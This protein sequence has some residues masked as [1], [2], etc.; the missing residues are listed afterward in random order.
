MNSLWSWHA[1]PGRLTDIWVAI[2]KEIGNNQLSP[3]HALPHAAIIMCYCMCHC[4]CC[5]LHACAA[6][7]AA[8]ATA[9]IGRY[10]P[11]HSLLQGVY[12]HLQ[13]V[14]TIIIAIFNTPVIMV[15]IAISPI[16]VPPYWWKMYS[17]WF[18]S[19][20]S[21]NSGRVSGR[22]NCKLQLLPQYG[23]FWRP[24]TQCGS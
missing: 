9:A 5:M 23:Q 11:V 19:Y 6:C 16:T 13:I 20:Q 10:M 17:T 22:G 14:G 7:A 15:N 4:M 21:G 12:T 1:Y 24:T 2:T 8:C 18:Y 3:V